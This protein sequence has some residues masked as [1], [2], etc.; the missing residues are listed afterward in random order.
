MQVPLEAILN[1][2][3]NSLH[4]VRSLI[5]KERTAVAEKLAQHERRADAMADDDGIMTA[6]CRE[7]DGKPATRSNGKSAEQ[8]LDIATLE[9]LCH[10]DEFDSGVETEREEGSQVTDMSESE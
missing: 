8:S 1:Y 6:T 3:S 10:C 4:A 9:R 7:D 2:D 5:E